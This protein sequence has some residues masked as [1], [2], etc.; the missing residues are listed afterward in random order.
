MQHVVGLLLS[1][2]QAG[3]INQQWQAPSSS[4]ATARH[5][6]AN[7]GSVTLTADVGR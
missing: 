6:A 1:T 5:S 4:S 2:V 7:A 3:D